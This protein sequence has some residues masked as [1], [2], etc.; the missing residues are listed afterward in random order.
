MDATELEK[1]KEAA[2]AELKSLVEKCERIHAG[3]E[4]S[5]YNED[6][7]RTE[8]I[9]LLFKS[10]GW[11]VYNT[12]TDDEVVRQE[13][14]KSRGSTKKVDYAFKSGGVT[15][16]FVEAKGLREDLE[17]DKFARQA[18]EYGFN[19]SIRY[20]VLT[21]FAKLKVFNCEWS[22]P[23][24]VRNLVFELNFKQFLSSGDFDKLWLLSKE[25]FKTNALDE[26]AR[27]IGKRTPSKE[28]A[29]L[30]LEQ[31][32]IWR[33]KLSSDL[34]KRYGAKYLDYD[35][36][37]AVQWLL[38]RL[39]FM[40][41]C[42][43]RG[44][45][46]ESLLAYLRQ[47]EQT[48]RGLWAKVHR[49]FSDYDGWYD[50]SLFRAPA[51]IDQMELD[52]KLVADVIRS[53]YYTPDGNR[54][55]NFALIPADILG[56]MYEQ[57]LSH[58]LR[59][60]PV[61]AK[62]EEKHAHRKEQGIYYTPTYIVDYIVKNT[63][64]EMLKGMKPADAAKIRVLDPACGS[65]SFLLKVFDH[66]EAYHRKNSTD[67]A[68]S[69]LDATATNGRLTMQGRILRDNIF[70]VDL[71]PKAVEFAQL[72]LMLK[73]A[74]TRAKLPMLDANI[75][76][77]NSL[78]DDAS[79]AGDKAFKWNE[80]FASVMKEDGFDVV[81]G[82]PPYIRPH[83]LP[84]KDKEYL[85]KNT[86]TFRAKSD[87]YNCFMEKGIKLLRPGGLIGFIVPH[88][89]T[90]LESFTLIRKFALDNCRIVKLVQLPKRVFQDATIET[91]VFIFQKEPDPRVRSNSD[92]FVERLDD[93]RKIIPVKKIKQSKIESN[94]LYNFELYSDASGG[95]LVS[96]LNALPKL[97]DIIEFY[98]GLKTGDDEKFISTDLKDKN[99]KKL[100]RS[101]DISRYWIKYSGEYVWYRPELM[102]K[103][104]ATAR[105]G[106]SER[107]EK[108]KLVIGRM[109]KS[110][111]GAYD[112]DGYYV[113]DGMLLLP[114]NDS[115]Q[116]KYLLALL[117][118]KLLNYYYQ[119]YFIT[120]DVLKNAILQLPIVPLTEMQ[121]QVL[122]KYVDKM[123]EYQKKLSV[124]GDKQSLERQRLEKEIQETDK[125]IDE[126]VYDLYGL[127][128]EERK[129]V[130]VAVK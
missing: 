90:S 46:E 122:S 93:Q 49:L 1:A 92:I 116:I 59:K 6:R 7:T 67:H 42:E 37:E 36:D 89:W 86:E 121:K 52:D 119:N 117:N 120:I 11:D 83:N 50:S 70:A 98:Y 20:A 107:F 53:L 96:K 81:V 29:D 5:K 8:L 103:N 74:E 39:I 69:Q 23:N 57:Y 41:H 10:L 27:S 54:R 130:D 24:I 88:S 72:N 77:G 51:L 94:Y 127:T 56:N 71:D 64:G 65:G 33:Q 18:I 14:V 84:E 60:T 104:K 79:V 110:L 35:I 28:V 112:E 99:S 102:I 16:F 82:N 45:E 48:G 13:S 2:R 61:R 95:I 78:I 3:S 21:N 115:A 66:L 19:R 26:Y 55:Y 30:L 9:D 75:Q 109:G 105:P 85:W 68:Q 126:M 58:L 113:K 62:L 111:F 118:S 124:F 97:A 17:D 128:P 125:K 76:N 43:D 44:I 114:K 100:V 101:A 108:P 34:S 4:I 12:H 80:R 123:C 25:S 106:S 91:C 87:L 32:G 73:A 129:I 22:E 63:L 15:K 31:M 47:Y 40:R 38:N